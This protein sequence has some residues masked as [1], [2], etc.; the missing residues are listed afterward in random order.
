MTHR[1]T[2]SPTGQQRVAHSA[3]PAAPPHHQRADEGP[4]GGGRR[5]G[6]PPSEILQ[7]PPKSAYQDDVYVAAELPV[8]ARRIQLW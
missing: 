1:G 6:D 3:V 2:A 5:G 7:R 4:G 8:W